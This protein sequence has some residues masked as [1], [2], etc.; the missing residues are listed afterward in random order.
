M[1]GGGFIGTAYEKTHGNA[2]ALHKTTNA[3]VQAPPLPVC[4][5]VRGRRDA[6]LKTDGAHA[7]TQLLLS[8]HL[9]RCLGLHHGL[10]K[11]LSIHW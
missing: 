4:K 3:L 7:L 5:L 9:N 2:K 1:Q 10:L 6:A 8:L 11:L